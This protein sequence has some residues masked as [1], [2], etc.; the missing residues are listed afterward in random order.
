MFHCYCISS[1]D[2]FALFCYYLIS[3]Y[4]SFFS[5]KIILVLTYSYLLGCIGLHCTQPYTHLPFLSFLT[6]N[7]IHFFCISELFVLSLYFLGEEKIVSARLRLFPL[8]FL[9]AYLANFLPIICQTVNYENHVFQWW[10]LNLKNVEP[11]AA[12]FYI[13]LSSLFPFLISIFNIFYFSAIWFSIKRLIA[14]SACVRKNYRKLFWIYP[15]F[16]NL[17]LKVF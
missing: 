16:F 17:T 6:F 15:F 8:I 2:L 7:H 14:Q 12:R 1:M 13:F 9:M 4:C 5:K 3:W 10:T 11:M